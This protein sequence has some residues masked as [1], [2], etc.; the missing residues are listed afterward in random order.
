VRTAYERM[1][2]FGVEFGPNTRL[3]AARRERI[4]DRPW[5]GPAPATFA[6]GVAQ[7]AVLDAIRRSAPQAGA[8]TD[9][10]PGDVS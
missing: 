2:T 10:E 5:S 9:V 4:L 1:T 3:A 6:D 8:W 7:M